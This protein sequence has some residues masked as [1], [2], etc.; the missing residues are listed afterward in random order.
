MSRIS[1]DEIC[2]QFEP[3]IYSFIHKYRLIHDQEEYVQIGRIALYEAWRRHDADLV[4]F[5]GYAKSYIRGYLQNAVTADRKKQERFVSAEPATLALMQEGGDDEDLRCCDI[6]L[7]CDSAGL[8]DRERN[9]LY[10]FVYRDLPIEAIARRH[11]VKATTVKTW[12]KSA[13]RKLRH[14]LKK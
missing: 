6:Q 8:S 10:D 1:F 7:V 9:W 4:S 3:L 5:P 12:R 14:E 2:N 13:V 11:G